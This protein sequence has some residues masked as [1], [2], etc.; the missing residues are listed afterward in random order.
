MPQAIKVGIFAALVLAVLGFFILKIEDLRLFAPEGQRVDALFD[1]VA[2]LDDKAAVRVAGVRIGKVDGVRL[3][4]QR[5]RVTLLL[6]QPVALTE[7]AKAVISATGLLGDKYVELVPGLPGGAP[8]PPGSVLDGETPISL[9]QAIARFD[10]IGANIEQITGSLTGSGSG[11]NVIARLLANLEEVSSQVRDLIAANRASVDG[12]IR[13]FEAASG[14]LAREL[15]RLADRLDATLAAIGDLVGENRENVAA[16]VENIRKVTEEMQ[17]V[18]A[19]LR[20]ISDRLAKGE[21][22][23]GKLLTSEEAHDGLVS[24]LESIKGGV[25]SLQETLG[26]AQRIKL[27]FAMQ[28]FTIPDRDKSQADFQLDIDT[29]T[30]WLYRV[31]VVDPADLVTR[32]KV[33]VFTE[34]L[35]D[36]TVETRTLETLSEEQKLRVSALLGKRFGK[37]LTLRTGLIESK[38]GVQA[39]YPLFDE[40]FLLTFQAWDFS[41]E[42][43]LDPHLRLTGRYN[44]HPNLYL[45]G[46]YDD[47]LVSDRDAF[48]IGA[49]IR[50]TDDDLKYILGA[51][52]TGF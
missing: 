18:I 39:D 10:K 37:D 30:D 23:I 44:L 25:G 50:W 15:P 24:T 51:A 13:N 43:S 42:Q 29:K 20:T 31:A 7:G 8:L 40:K 32:R 49:G 41:R 12:T 9:D 38:F 2:G 4:G 34:T 26:A 35:P 47:P 14:T 6:E 33:Q 11:D 22:T 45:L 21:G 16:S 48:F 36:G 17:P 52:P 3:E 1:S 19:D 27:D 28:G 5:A 46:G